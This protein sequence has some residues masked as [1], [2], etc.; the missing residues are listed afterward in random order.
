[1]IIVTFL[2]IDYF[3][4][5]VLHSFDITHGM[6]CGRNIRT[7]YNENSSLA[8]SYKIFSLVS[9]DSCL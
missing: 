5:C 7:V 4:L 2:I 1:M 9:F 8:F 3:V 6:L